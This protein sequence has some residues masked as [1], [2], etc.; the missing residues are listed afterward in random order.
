MIINCEECKSEF[1]L[2]ESLIKEDGTKVRCSVCKNVFV[3]YP[4]VQESVE[5]VSPEDML[6][7]DDLEETVAINSYNEGMMGVMPEADD[8]PDIDEES[9]GVDLDSS[10]GGVEDDILDQI[11]EDALEGEEVEE[12]EL[13]EPDE[14]YEAGILDE[15]VEETIPRE[16]EEAIFPR[17]RPN[18][19][20]SLII[21][22]FI[23][24]ILFSG[25]TVFYLYF[26]GYI[27]G[28]IKT[29]DT[30]E[31]LIGA[32]DTS[33]MAIVVN[34]GITGDLFESKKNGMLF[35][36]AGSITNESSEVRSFVRLKGVIYGDNG[37][38]LCSKLAYATNVFTEEELHNSP[39]EE[40]NIG[41]ENRLGEGGSNV[42]IQPHQE[43]PFMII[44]DNLPD[45]SLMSEF[46]VEAVSSS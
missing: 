25:G 38:E 7:E 39:M 40:L 11:F 33:A 19:T 9:I 16:E 45:T 44:L 22:V 18:K 8:S 20:R 30:P 42:D 14:S 26:P 31:T 13:D 15:E 46:E 41:M 37:T 5:A 3:A 35:V 43:V 32:I 1:N 28:F 23:I 6:D 36:I 2:D 17:E 27:P 12:V 29:S 24:L 34:E 21:L 4:P 10:A